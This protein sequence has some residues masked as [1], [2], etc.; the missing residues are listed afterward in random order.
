[1]ALY[2]VVRRAIKTSFIIILWTVKCKS[3]YTDNLIVKY[4]SP[5]GS[6]LTCLLYKYIFCDLSLRK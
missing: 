6:E 2:S 1:M 5:R 3:Y 4:S